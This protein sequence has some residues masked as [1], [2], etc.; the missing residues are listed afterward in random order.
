[1]AISQMDV[2]ARQAYIVAVVSEGERTSAAGITNLSRNI[3]QSVSPSLTGA[4]IQILSSLSAP[5]L[6]GGG[7]KIAYDLAVYF[8]FR[9]V[10]LANE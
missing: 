7:L 8:N 10:K 9:R 1:M 4:L 2:P 5:F 6:I 3:A